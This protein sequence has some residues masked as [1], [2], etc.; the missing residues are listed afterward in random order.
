M[1][2][3]RGKTASLAIA[4]FMLTSGA[5][6]ETVNMTLDEGVK[7]ALERNYS[8]EES[9]ADLESAKWQHKE[10][11][12]NSGLTL[13]WS[14][15]ASAIGG[16]AYNQYNHKGLFTNQ[17][18]LSM[19]LYT[20]GRIEN[21]IKSAK[22]GISGAELLLER[23]R[24]DVRD[25]VS[26]DYYNILR[27]RSQVEVYQESVNNL[28]AHLENTQA[29]FRA[30]T[31]PQTDILSSEVSLAQKKQ[32]LVS[33][34][35]DYN[36]AV[37][38]F[39]NDV[40]LPTDTDTKP[41]DRLAYEAYNLD[42]AECES[43]AINHRPDLFQKEYNLLQKIAETDAA[44]SGARPYVEAVVGRN[45]GGSSPFKT[46]NDTS[47]SWSAGV[48]ANWNVFDNQITAAQVEQKKAAARRAEAEL[49]DALNDVKLEVR[50]AYLNLK[51]A[52]ENIKTM[53]EA[54]DKAKE[55]YRIEQVRYNAGVGTNLEIMDAQEKLVSAKGDYI[56]ALY[57]YNT[58]KASL[59]RAMGVPVKLDT[60]PYKKALEQYEN[61]GE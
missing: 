4:L 28:Q 8:I 30:G 60:E 33:A 39:N 54:L 9:A 51:A 50:T 58:S 47:D 6:A 15:D 23:T 38:T 57:S 5:S 14:T 19:P 32:K 22:L 49:K 17:V 52:E 43:Y 44:K 53:R 40:G 35:N 59:D 11:R 12:R 45:F 10:A 42:L 27:C 13:A 25:T 34:I 16:K 41:Q 2:L 29:K 55:D 7:M 24:Q 46:D 56:S 37:A 26:Q 3:R 18:T 20:G 21:N 48:K 1:K 31:I 36:V 61:K